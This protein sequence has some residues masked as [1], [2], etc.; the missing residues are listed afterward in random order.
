MLDNI[1]VNVLDVL[2]IPV[3]M[4]QDVPVDMILDMI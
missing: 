1:I 4:T 2:D 3:N